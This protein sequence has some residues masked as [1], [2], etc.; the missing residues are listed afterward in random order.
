[1]RHIAALLA[2]LIAGCDAAGPR[3]AE[4]SVV[5]DSVPALTHS[6]LSE[7][8][9]RMGLLDQT[10]RVGFTVNTAADTGFLRA[11]L[12]IDSLLT[13]RLRRIIDEY[14][15][16]TW[17]MVGESAANAAFLIAQHSPSD[18]FQREVLPLLEAA[19][20]ADEAASSDVA[21]LTDRVRTHDGKPQVYGTQFRIIDGVLIPYPIEDLASLDERRA[22]AGLMPMA[23]YVDMLRQTYGGPV[24]W[25][26]DTLVQPPT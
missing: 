10:V 11:T 25:P 5:A 9:V 4:P 14:G 13:Q 21:L 19:A 12:G 26:P 23:E 20:A 17:S 2:V 3:V 1:M 16:P 15:W 22:R 8:L 7:Q 6:S 24:R 18:R